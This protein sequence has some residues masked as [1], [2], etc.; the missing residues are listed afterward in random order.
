MLHRRQ[1]IAPETPTGA[2]L[3]GV[4]VAGDRAY[5][6][7]NRGVLLC[8]IGGG[9]IRLLGDGVAGESRGLLD[10]AA[11]DDGER[12]WLCGPRGALGY[13]DPDSGTVTDCSEPYGLDSTLRTLSVDGVTGTEAVHVGDD[14]GRI[15]RVT[16]DGT[17]PTVRGVAV[18]GP[19][20]PITEIRTADGLLFAADTTGRLH[21]SDDGRTWRTDQLASGAVTALAVDADGLLAA[22][23]DGT[24]YTGIRSFSSPPDRLAP[25]PDGVRPSAADGRGHTAVVVGRNGSLLVRGRDPGFQRVGVESSAGLYAVTIDADGAI[26][27][28]GAEGLIVEGRA[29]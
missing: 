19:N 23:R 1:W 15:A 29:E 28:V 2:Q 13:Y 9:W 4:A 7:G 14:R 26:Y 5:V 6:A 10:V 18:P 27:A 20:E 21:Q 12:L 8:R 17:D 3:N 24:V 25:L 22:T 16:V 11:T